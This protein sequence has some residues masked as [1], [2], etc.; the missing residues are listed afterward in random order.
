VTDPA[1]LSTLV[2]GTVLVVRANQTRKDVARHALRSLTAVG[3]PVAGIVL[4][5]VDFS[6]S[7]YKYSYYYYQREGDYG[8]DETLAAHRGATRDQDRP[9]AGM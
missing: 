1:V 2:D 9:S 7:E 5:S 3:G 6:R 8:A 4:N